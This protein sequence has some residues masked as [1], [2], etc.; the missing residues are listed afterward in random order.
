MNRSDLLTLKELSS[1]KVLVPLEKIPESFKSDFNKFFFGKTLV[2][3]K[4]KN[5]FADPHDVK[6]WVQCVFIDYK[7]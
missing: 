5:L 1:T 3:D 6:R 2:E 4:N 7:D